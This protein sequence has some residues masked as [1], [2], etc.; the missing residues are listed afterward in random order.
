MNETA[1][2]VEEQ[3]AFAYWAELAGT[4]TDAPDAWERFTAER[5]YAEGK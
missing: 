4:T 3:E 5:L 2:T 1:A